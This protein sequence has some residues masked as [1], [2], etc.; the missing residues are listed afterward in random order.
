MG[1]TTPKARAECLLKL[2]DVIE[3]N[4]Q[5]LP[6]WS[7]VIV[8]NRCIARSMMKFRRLSMS[9]AFSPVRRCLNGLAA[10]EYLEGHTSMIRRDPLG[11]VASIAP[12]NYPLMMAAWKLAPALAAGNCV[13]LKP[14]EITPLTA[15]KLA[16]LAKDIFPAGVINVLFGRGKTVGDPLT[17]HPKVRMVS[18]TGSIATGNTSSAIPRRPLSVLIWNLVAKAP[19]IVF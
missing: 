7:P 19:V 18:L 4:G 6:N 15:L 14:S 16:E 8:A 2:A 3:E 12:W 10:G 9:F 1:Q 13:V 5:V 17:G 11:V